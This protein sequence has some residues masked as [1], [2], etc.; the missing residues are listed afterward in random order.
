MEY[1]LYLLSKIGDT[2]VTLLQLAGV[3]W[4]MYKLLFKERESYE[5]D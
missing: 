5:R 2:L 4:V 1:T 3:S